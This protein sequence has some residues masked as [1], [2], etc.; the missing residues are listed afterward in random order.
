MRLHH[1]LNLASFSEDLSYISPSMLQHVRLYLRTNTLQENRNMDIIDPVSPFSSPT[2]IGLQYY[3]SMHLTD[4]T[5]F[6][7]LEDL[8]VQRNIR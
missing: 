8:L 2:L 3:H 7:Y 1:I 6:S 5:P 4:A